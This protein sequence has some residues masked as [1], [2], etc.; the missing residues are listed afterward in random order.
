MTKHSG[1]M[2]SASWGGGGVMLKFSSGQNQDTW[3]ILDFKPTSNGK[4]ENLEY[5]GHIECYNLSN[6]L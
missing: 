6:E 2:I 4:L 5:K 3:T 1:V